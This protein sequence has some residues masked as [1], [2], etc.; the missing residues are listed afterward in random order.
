MTFASDPSEPGTARRVIVL[1]TD[2]SADS[3]AA[4]GPTA[5]LAKKLNAR[6]LLL[7]VVCDAPL[8]ESA[9]ASLPFS[10]NAWNRD[11]EAEVATARQALHRVA[12]GMREHLAAEDVEEVVLRGECPDAVIASVAAV[13]DAEF[14]AMASH[15]RTGLR[16]LLIG[17]VTEQVIRRSNIPVIVFPVAA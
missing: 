9:N 16:R 3:L 15:G 7:T 4:V 11:V 13:R 17:S 12:E 14:I 5:E 2:G 1:T 6:V 8:P 10:T